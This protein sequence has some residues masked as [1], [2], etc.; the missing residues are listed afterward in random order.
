[1]TLMA[2]TLAADMLA[3]NSLFVPQKEI[4]RLVRL[5]ELQP[6]GSIP[7]NPAEAETASQVSGQDG[8]GLEPDQARRTS[9]REISVMT[10]KGKVKAHHQR[11]LSHDD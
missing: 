5:L 8:K 7:V 11:M 2:S 10:E 4:A 3:G 9:E 6:T 1:M